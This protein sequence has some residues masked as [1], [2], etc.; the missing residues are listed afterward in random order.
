MIFRDY[1]PDKLKFSVK[2]LVLFIYLF[3]DSVD[4]NHIDVYGYVYICTGSAVPCL[5]RWHIWRHMT[6]CLDIG[7]PHDGLLPF[8]I[9]NGCG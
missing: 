3:I 1:F 4:S 6:C 8:R 9:D 7:P 2:M 5:L